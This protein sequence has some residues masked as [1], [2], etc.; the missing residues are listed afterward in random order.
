MTLVEVIVVIVILGVLAAILLPAFTA[1]SCRCQ[2]IN[3]VNNLKQIGLAYRIWAGDNGGKYPMQFSVTNGGVF[4]FATGSNSWMVYSVMSNELSTPK[5][6]IC[7]QDRKSVLA[8]DF[9][10]AF[11]N[12]NVSYFVGL[13]ADEDH[14]QMILSGDDNFAVGGVPIKSGL[15]EFPTNA[16]ISWTA[17]RHKY[18]GNIGLVDG[19]VVSTSSSLLHQILAESG[20]AT[21]RFAIP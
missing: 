20:L 9:G 18:A 21:N 19:S 16:P 11:N 15:L 10:K 2:K 12:S 1:N 7:P 17:A 3:C 4:E 5:V 14:P 13:N 8:N 6:V